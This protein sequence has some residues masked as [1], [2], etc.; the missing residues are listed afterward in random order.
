MI[1]THALERGPSGVTSRTDRQVRPQ[2]TVVAA[3]PPVRSC[4]R[5]RE[6]RADGRL[7]IPASLSRSADPV[8]L[9]EP[10]F[11]IARRT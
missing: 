8:S 5:P 10:E 7:S 1:C 4:T 11:P 2:P 9:D 6:V 3:C